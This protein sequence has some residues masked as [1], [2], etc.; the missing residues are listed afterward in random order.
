MVER[1]F[2]MA[3]VTVKVPS[4]RTRVVALSTGKRGRN[5][6]WGRKLSAVLAK[7]RKVDSSAEPVVYFIPKKNAIC[8]F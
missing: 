5:L 4:S 2:Q 8:L 1:G 3:P 7:A 6:A